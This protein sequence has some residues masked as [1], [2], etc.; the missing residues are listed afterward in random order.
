MTGVNRPLED[1]VLYISHFSF[2]AAFAISDLRREGELKIRLKVANR[3]TNSRNPNSSSLLF[4]LLP[5]PSPFSRSI[6]PFANNPS[7]TSKQK[8]T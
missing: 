6:Y 8:G 2:V 3:T 5:T 7:T 4:C 1:I